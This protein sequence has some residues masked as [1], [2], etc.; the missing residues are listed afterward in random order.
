[1]RLSNVPAKHSERREVLA[2]S[3]RTSPRHPQPNLGQ[4]EITPNGTTQLNTQVGKKKIGSLPC[5]PREQRSKIPIYV[6]T[7]LREAFEQ[8]YVHDVMRSSCD[9]A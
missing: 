6:Y 8:A 7:G 4:Q 1:M 3:I 2:A 9:G 5:R